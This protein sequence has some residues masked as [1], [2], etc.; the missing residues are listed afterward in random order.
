VRGAITP[1]S[2]ARCSVTLARLLEPRLIAFGDD[3]VHPHDAAIE[4]RV[5][6]DVAAVRR[7][8]LEH[9]DRLARAVIRRNGYQPFDECELMML[10]RRVVIAGVAIEQ[11]EREVQVRI[12]RPRA[13]ARVI[14]RFGPFVVVVFQQRVAE[15]DVGQRLVRML[16]IGAGRRRNY[17]SSERAPVKVKIGSRSPEK[18]A[19]MSLTIARQLSSVIW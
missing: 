18:N 17:A 2:C 15:V 9:V 7:E 16:V 14:R 11:R 3:G 19:I 1:P 12:V 10:E 4:E 6:H 13:Q 5:R 8:Y